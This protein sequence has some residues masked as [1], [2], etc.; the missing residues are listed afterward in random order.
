MMFSFAVRMVRDKYKTSIAFLGGSIIF[1][2][3]YV[4]LYPFLQ[5]Q[6]A[7]FEAMIK[8]MPAEFFSAFNMDASS[9]SF[10]NMESYLS[11]EFMSF[12]W[13]ILA[14]VLAVILANYLIINEIDNGTVEALGS[15]PVSRIRIFMERYF[16]GLFMLVAFSAISML[17]TPILCEIHGIDYI[18][19]NYLTAT[20]G[21]ILFIW[22]IY[23]LAILISTFLSEKEKSNMF[24]GGILMMMYVV[25]IVA[26]LNSDL[27]WLK[28]FSFFNY[29]NGTDI[30]AKA[31]MPDYSLLV[32][33][34][35][36]VIATVVAWRK[37]LAR[38]LV[39]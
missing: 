20:L 17:M 9:F 39:V 21:S 1:L 3:M 12:L 6:S 13:P 18:F 24:V 35:F 4:A 30:L 28:Y 23:S 33:V 38:D 2:E 14:I 19:G 10:S 34:G 27:K 16:T 37:F 26:S 22:A 8:S 31:V 32:F 36:S 11:T 29:F 25:S 5:K 15:L 7:S